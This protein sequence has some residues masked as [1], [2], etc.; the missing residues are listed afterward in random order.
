MKKSKGGEGRIIQNGGMTELPQKR[1][2]WIDRQ[3]GKLIGR[4][5]NR[6]I[7]AGK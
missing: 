2:G 1:D 4:K 7:Q 3:A 5:I 6:D